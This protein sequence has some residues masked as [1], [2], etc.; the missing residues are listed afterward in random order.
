MAVV[1]RNK[2]KQAAANKPVEKPVEKP[3][4]AKPGEKGPEAA[5]KKPKIK[6]VPYGQRDAEG[7]LLT[8]LTG[9]PA[10]FNPKQHEGLKRKDFASLADFLDFRASEVEAHAKALRQQAAD[11]RSGVG[12][13]TKGKQKRLI[14]LHSQYEALM[15]ELQAAGVDVQAA[16]ANA[17]KAAAEKAAAEQAAAEQAAP[18]A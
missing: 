10:D 17:A 8:K 18:Q 4:A 16:L 14:N 2:G 6:R 7:E 11:E 15:K 9:K 5:E 1:N 13:V 3:V 12:K